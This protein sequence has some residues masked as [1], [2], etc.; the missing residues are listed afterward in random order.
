MLIY[1]LRGFSAPK[2]PLPCQPPTAGMGKRAKKSTEK[3]ARKGKKNGQNRYKNGTKTAAKRHK[4][5]HSKTIHKS[6]HNTTK[7][8]TQHIKGEKFYPPDSN[9]ATEA[10]C[11]IR[12]KKCR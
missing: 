10:E 4:A 11:K 3:A 1:I 12:Q 6:I 9:E 5:V 2:S 7:V 8:N